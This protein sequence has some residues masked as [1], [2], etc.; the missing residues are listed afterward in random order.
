M[1]EQLEYELNQY[2]QRMETT[3]KDFS[4]K[5]EELDITNHHLEQ[6]KTNAGVA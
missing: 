1:I 2:R 6:E 4:D 5:K 3:L